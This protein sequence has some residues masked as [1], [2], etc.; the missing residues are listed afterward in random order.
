MKPGDVV[1]VQNGSGLREGCATW[2]LG[3]NT[4]MPGKIVDWTKAATLAMVLDVKYVT[5]FGYDELIEYIRVLLPG[6]TLW[7]IGFNA[8]EF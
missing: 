1:I 8:I 4:V 5:M 3:A 2:P 7:T 6:K